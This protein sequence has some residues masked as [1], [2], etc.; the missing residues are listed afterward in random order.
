MHVEDRESPGLTLNNVK[1]RPS[2]TIYDLKCRVSLL[3]ALKIF[4]FV[5]DLVQINWYVNYINI[6]GNVIIRGFIQFW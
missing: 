1:V 6:L 2:D 5:G 3:L 4:I